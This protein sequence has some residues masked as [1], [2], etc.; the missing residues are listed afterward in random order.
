[1]AKKKQ[2][3]KRASKRKK[4]PEVYNKLL[5]VGAYDATHRKQLQQRAKKVQQL[6][7]QAVD[8][9]ARAAAPSLFDT[10]PA[11]EFHFSDF[12]ALNKSVDEFIDDMGKQLQ[13]N[14]E[15]GDSDAWTLANAKNDMVVNT[16]AS[17]YSLPKETLAAWRHPHLDAL[18][19]FEERRKNGMNLSNGGS[20]A[21]IRKGVWNLDQFK[22]ELEL[23]LEQ[24]IGQGKSAVDLSRDVR[25]YLKYPNKLFRRVRDK[26]GVL[27]LSK[28][29]AAF[30]PGR[31]VYRSSYKNALRLTATENNIAYRTCDHKRWNALPFVLGQEIKTSNN[32]PEPDICDTLAGKYPIEFKFT[33]WH[34][35]CRCYAVSILAN[36]KELDDYCRRIEN[37]EEVSNYKFAGK[38]DDFPDELKDWVEDNDS[39][40]VSAFVSQK[41]PYFL[42]DNPENL[43]KNIQKRIAHISDMLRVKGSGDYKNAGFNIYTGAVRATHIG[44][45]LDKKKG[46]YE[47]AVQDAGFKEGHS[48]IL[49]KEPQNAFKKKSTEGTW[50]G[51]RFEIAAAETNTPNNIR[52]AL[53][54]CASKRDTEVAVVFFPN[55]YI[56]SVFEDGL[57][58]F[59]GL[60]GTTQYK[61][62]LKIIC[63][64]NGKIIKEISRTQ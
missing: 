25:Q 33:G 20:E 39:R 12:P 29:A 6:Y 3:S 64:H 60:K 36:G 4:L 56:P 2:E 37:G 42:A 58:K 1:M 43:P 63:I 11:K 48:V 44:H 7:K 50:D 41:L 18:Q 27:R 31:G 5:K 57:G 59:R 8:K 52:N 13:A 38:V 26:D 46:W 17:V 23:A 28:A 61:D 10:D 19:E 24:G 14:I 9:I 30:H 53:K 34:P 40:I 22:N 35:F 47:T 15:D 45:N 55:G 21:D 32:H 49:E 16:L 62:F 54:H 51:Q